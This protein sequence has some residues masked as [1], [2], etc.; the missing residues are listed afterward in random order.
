MKFYDKGQIILAEGDPTDKMFL[1]VN[2]CL[3]VYL[4]FEGNEFII[5]KLKPG[6]ILNYLNIFTDDIMKV[7]VRS[8]LSGDGTYVQYLNV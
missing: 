2:G 1:V 6:S 8:K 3:E 5:E 4:E 7:N